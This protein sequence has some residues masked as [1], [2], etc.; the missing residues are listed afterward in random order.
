M[1]RVRRSTGLLG[2]ALT[3]TLDRYQPPGRPEGRDIDAVLDRKQ[4]CNWTNNLY[5]T[6]VRQAGDK[7]P[8][9]VLAWSYT[10]RHDQAEQATS[11]R[12]ATPG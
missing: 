9:S 12:A 3:L 11:L 4:S 1:M 6:Q 7:H 5:Q 2:V 10:R 8:L